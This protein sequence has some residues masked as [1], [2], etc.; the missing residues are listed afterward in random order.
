MLS[1]AFGL[2]LVTVMTMT[3]GCAPRL[4]F[5]A[6]LATAVVAEAVSH[7]R[8]VVVE[9]LPPPPPVMLV[10]PMPPP[11]PPSFVPPPPS[12]P[13]AA[14]LFDQGAAHAA[15]GAVDPSSCWPAG[16]V[17]GY[18]KARVTFSP[19]GTV[20]LVEITNPMPGPP[21]DNACISQK[22]GAVKVPPFD[23]GNVAASGTFFVR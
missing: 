18:G 2:G 15:L 6:V 3:A 13:P 7:P 23:G 12:S 5:P 9:Q 8:V 16:A 20:K 1:K 22:Y 4:L 14:R 17:R 21:P 19:D 11:P 10:Q